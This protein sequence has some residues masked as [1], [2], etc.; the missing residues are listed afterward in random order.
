LPPRYAAHEDRIKPK[1]MDVRAVFESMKGG[2]LDAD[3]DTLTESL[4]QCFEW[5]SMFETPRQIAPTLSYL[6]HELEQGFDGSPVI[7]L[8]DEFERFMKYSLMVERADRACRLYRDRNV[9][10]IIGTQAG[11]DIREASLAK[12]LAQSCQTSFF[13]PNPAAL[14]DEREDYEAFRLSPH[15]IERLASEPP[16]RSYLFKNPHGE[17]WFELRLDGLSLEVLGRSRREHHRQMDA[18]LAA[19]GQEGF[20]R[21]WIEAQGVACPDPPLIRAAGE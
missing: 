12:L 21:A 9:S 5:E 13:T 2:L 20:W 15:N 4:V 18:L 16:K 3:H 6:W 14:G 10:M 7:F 19:H 11:D 8:W 1:Q 17:R